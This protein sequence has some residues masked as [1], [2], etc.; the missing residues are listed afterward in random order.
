MRD[1]LWQAR[2]ETLAPFSGKGF[3][4]KEIAANT[5]L[6][7][8]TVRKYGK[9]YGFDF[10][11]YKTEIREEGDAIAT[12]LDSIKRCASEG[13]T[14]DETAAELGVGARTVGNY[15]RKFGLQFVHGKT[16]QCADVPRAEAMAAMFQG[17]KTLAEI[18]AFYGVTRE[19]VRQIIKK[20]HGLVAEHGGSHVKSERRQS[21]KR[22]THD[23][24]CLK[25]YGCTYQQYRELVALGQELKAGGLS[26][27]RTPTRAWHSQKRNALQ[28][29][30]EWNITLWDWWQIWQKSGKWASRGREVG[31]YVMCRF[32]DAGAYEV[33][34]VYIA[35]TSHNCSVQP[36]HP[37]ARKN[38]EY[39]AGMSA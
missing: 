31:Q 4:F 14:R 21:A 12:L 22:V 37:R 34:N 29:G 9:L 30:I 2:A 20:Q 39:G 26:N 5:G 6:T 35:T 7:A 28:R 33:G 24:N 15:G 27:S 25:K 38:V 8:C 16:G 11:S 36:N 3:T 18:G 17:G 13:K 10:G 32:G 23:Q 19:R 1:D